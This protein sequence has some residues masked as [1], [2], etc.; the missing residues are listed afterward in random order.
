MPIYSNNKVAYLTAA[1]LFGAAAGMAMN[2]QRK[3]YSFRGRSVII[4]GGSRGLGLELARQLARQRARLT[5][6]AR[7]LMELKRAERELT[8]MGAEVL[9]VS[10]DV[11][12]QKEVVE[13]VARTVTT[14]GRVDIL[15]NN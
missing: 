12:Q 4:T 10:C 11:R 15:I 7:D 2:R 8:A 14:M 1:L 9:T 13:A 5:L 3:R 6:I